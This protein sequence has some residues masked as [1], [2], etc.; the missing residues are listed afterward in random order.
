MIYAVSHA[1]YLYACQ[2]YLEGNDRERT[3]L[4]SVLLQELPKEGCIQRL[5]VFVPSVPIVFIM[6]RFYGKAVD[7]RNQNIP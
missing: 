7:H 4:H 1:V 6:I 2:R 5:T 3:L